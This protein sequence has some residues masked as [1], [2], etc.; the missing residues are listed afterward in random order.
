MMIFYIKHINNPVTSVK[1]DAEKEDESAI[2]S[3]MKSL[4]LV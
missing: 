3:K 4:S 1:K 2:R